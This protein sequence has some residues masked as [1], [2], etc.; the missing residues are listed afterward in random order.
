[1]SK[2]L[3]AFDALYVV[4]DLHLGDDPTRSMFQ[5]DARLGAFIKFV[6]DQRPGERVALALNG[7]IVDFLAGSAGVAFDPLRAPERLENIA[8]SYPAVFRELKSFTAKAGRRLILVLGNHDIELALPAVTG[9]LLSLICGKD[10]DR[11]RVILALDGAGLRCEIGGRSVFI[12]HGNDS[13]DWNVVDHER[14]RK[15]AAA[16]NMGAE[17]PSW[18]PN[19]GTTLVVKVLNKVKESYPWIELLKPEGYDLAMLLAAI[20]PAQAKHFESAPEIAA[21]FTYGFL[22]TRLLG[23][24]DEEVEARPATPPTRATPEA[25]RSV[26]AAAIAQVDRGV[27]PTELVGSESLGWF[28]PIVSRSDGR[29]DLSKVREALKRWQDVARDSFALTHTS[30]AD[31]AFLE[32]VSPNIDIV[33]AGHTHIARAQPRIAPTRDVDGVAWYFNSGT[34]I[35]LVDIRPR[36]LETDREFSPVWAMLT[37][38]NKTLSELIA[39]PDGVLRNAA[40]AVRIETRGAKVCGELLRF[41]KRGDEPDVEKI[42]ACEFDAKAGG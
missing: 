16:I 42:G 14:L 4:S 27:R 41:S 29:A 7:D 18:T 22:R 15:T 35:A 11:G 21:K 39:A 5:D 20:D 3:H 38:K 1:M 6:G 33:V 8:S 17:P 28:W 23:E 34:W 36:L 19:A 12:V 13:D 25:E 9:S 10:E 31:A 24:E 30:A 37:N 26:V 32:G 40:A 2:G